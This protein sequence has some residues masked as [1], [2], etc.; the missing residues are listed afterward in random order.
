ML[1]QTIKDIKQMKFFHIFFWTIAMSSML[2]GYAQT[3]WLLPTTVS[4]GLGGATYI[5]DMQ[6]TAFVNHTSVVYYPEDGSEPFV[7]ELSSY[8][9]LPATWTQ[10]DAI[11]KWDATSLMLFKGQEYVLLNV[12]GPSLQYMGAF[13]GLP[14][15]WGGSFDAAS[16]WVDSQLLFFKGTQYVIYDKNTQQMTTINIIADFAGWDP[17]WTS[18]DAV[19]NKEDGY[20]YF[21]HNNGYQQ[22]NMAT[23]T[24]EGGII[25]MSAPQS[26]FGAPPVAPVT[27]P[28]SFGTPPT[29]QSTTIQ[30]LTA[31]AVKAVPEDKAELD[32]SSWCLTGTPPGQSDE[33]LIEHFTTMEGKNDAISEDNVTAGTRVAEIRVWG[34][35]VV[36]GIQT[37]LQ[38]TDGRL[39]EL[40]VLGTQKGRMQTFKVKEGA[41]IT[42]VQGTSNGN[43]GIALHDLTIMTS[44]G[45]SQRFGKRGQ[46][47]F[48]IKIPS[49]TSFYGFKVSSNKNITG[50]SLKYVGYE[51][52]IPED[53]EEVEEEEVTDRD[54]DTSFKDKYRGEYDDEFTDFVDDINAESVGFS[55]LLAISGTDALG[56]G[57]D[58]LTLD[59][60][61]ISSTLKNVSVF[62]VLINNKGGGPQNKFQLPYGV[63]YKGN[64]RGSK[65]S[66]QKFVQ[67][68][69]DYQSEFGRGIGVGADTP[70]GGGSLSQ[71]YNDMNSSSLGSQHIY[72]TEHTERLIHT[73]SSKPYWI[74][75]KGKK[76]LQLNYDFRAMVDELPVPSNFPIIATKSIKKK[77]SL[78]S[79]VREVEGAYMALIN[80]YGTH[81]VAEAVL[82]GRYVTSTRITKQYYLDQRMSEEEFKLAVSAPSGKKGKKNKNSGDDD[83]DDDKNKKLN[84]GGYQ[85]NNSESSSSGSSN[86]NF[87][88]ETYISGSSGKSIFSDWSRDLQNETAPVK[89]DL[90]GNY[91]FL[92][93]IFWPNDKEIDKKRELLRMIT[94]KYIVDNAV[95]R[96]DKEGD[97]FGN[98]FGDAAVEYK[99]GNLK[100]EVVRADEIDNDS[101]IYGYI[102]TEF[103]Q[104]GENI[105]KETPK[106]IN[107]SN[108]L[109]INQGQSKSLGGES[110]T[111]IK[112]SK[113]IKGA[114]FKV[115]GKFL[116]ADGGGNDDDKLG[117][118]SREVYLDKFTEKRK[119]YT[120]EFSHDGDVIKLH[121]D[122]WKTSTMLGG[123]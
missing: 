104:Y 61:D 27:P 32:T 22:L 16:Q 23:Q 97:F 94:M 80:E 45:A 9:E 62:E 5:T 78:P 106:D 14:G 30:V 119:T 39:E 44:S 107:R 115:I 114:K 103:T 100:I 65:E 57:V 83:D 71:S 25:Q 36:T 53:K 89:V 70:K 82:G 37:V 64:Q 12:N 6:L 87:E 76:R 13:P 10:I 51:S 29:T 38:H 52:A 58:Y 48:E 40:T 59:P 96:P 8:G 121:F 105:V 95:I 56:K 46:K 85:Q 120:M 17:N 91:E 73:L 99:I 77:K 11:A 24:F 34:S 101:E 109:T 26:N 88:S 118:Q 31:S 3:N 79:Q 49:N 110:T 41:C 116:E 112:A 20:L 84:G 93:K 50:I 68:S 18:I 123:S 55:N 42:G 75:A 35:Y 19:V 72:L 113:S 108:S 92:T 117:T 102:K 67:K 63:S 111:V 66:K 47:P 21:F 81:Y 7:A 1:I 74:S 4:S 2:S 86:S 98:T 54:S 28:S 122:A 15:D 69:S 60:I 33:D 43:Y 90:K